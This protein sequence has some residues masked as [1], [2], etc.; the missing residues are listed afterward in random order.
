MDW[1]ALQL[2]DAAFPTG[3][4][5]HSAGLEAAISIGEVTN[6]TDLRQFVE[7]VVW[8]AGSAALP[9]ATAAHRAPGRVAELDAW[10]EAF[11]THAVANRASRTQGRAF[12]ATCARIFPSSTIAMLDESVRKKKLA[13]HYAPVFGVALA[14][15]GVD[16]PTMRE[17]FLHVS[18]RGVLSAGVRLGALG[19]HEAQGLQFELASLLSKVLEQTASLDAETAHQPAPLIDLFASLHDRQY[20]RLFQS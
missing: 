4:F 11:L 18:L 5:A 20:S 17:L 12:I 6:A 10:S 15:L 7:C 1:I 14:A 3:G 8:Q 13:G 9:F 2:A 19:P 16:L